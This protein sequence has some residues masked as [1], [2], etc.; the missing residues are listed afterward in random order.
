MIVQLLQKAW[1]AVLLF[2]PEIKY[3]LWNQNITSE[4]LESKINK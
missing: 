3:S 1:N 2:C 4:K